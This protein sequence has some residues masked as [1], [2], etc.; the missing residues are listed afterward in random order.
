MDGQCV[1]RWA[2]T[3]L[4]ALQQRAAAACSAAFQA[5]TQAHQPALLQLLNHC[6]GLLAVLEALGGRQPSSR[7]CC[8]RY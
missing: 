8:A 2:S 5:P 6:T 3:S 4:H 1:Q 7:R